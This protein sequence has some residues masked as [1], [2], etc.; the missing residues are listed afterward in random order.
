MEATDTGLSQLGPVNPRT[1]A[2]P[3]VSRG[4]TN[5][6]TLVLIIGPT[7]TSRGGNRL[8][9]GTDRGALMHCRIPPAGERMPWMPT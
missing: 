7:A 8:L 2:W 6:Q 1:T 9:Q 4:R 5:P 3:L